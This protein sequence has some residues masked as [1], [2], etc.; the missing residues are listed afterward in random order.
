MDKPRLLLIVLGAALLLGAGGPDAAAVPRHDICADVGDT[1]AFG[2]SSFGSLR[3]WAPEAKSVY[4]A[5]FRFLYVYVL[6]GGMDNPAD[7]RD[8]Y[9]APFLQAARDMDAV[10]VLTFYQLL[11]LGQDAGYSGS[12]PEV[13]AEALQ[14]PDVMRTYFDNFVWL[15]QLCADEGPP[16][17]VHVEPDS[18]GFMQW[19]MGIEGNDDPTSVPVK[20]TGSG[21]P[22]VAGYPDHAAGLGQALVGLRDQ[23]APEVRLGWH[24]SN[25]RVGTHPEVTTSFF[26]QMGDWD[27]LVGEHPHLEPDE[28][29]WWGD[30]DAAAV[31]TNLHWFDEVTTSAGLPM[32]LWQVPIGTMDYHL[33]S[34]PGDLSMLTRFAE[35][36]IVAVLFEHQAFAGETDPDLIR[37]SGALGTPPPSGSPAGG[38]AADMRQR[39]ADYS[40]AP[41]SWPADTL[42][43]SGIDTVDAG[44]PPQADGGTIQGDGGTPPPDDSGDSGCGCRTTDGPA[45]LPLLLLVWL[46]FVGWRRSRSQGGIT[47]CTAL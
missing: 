43:A 12:E 24:A 21:H 46:L 31:D 7:F 35:V 23:Y 42:C 26:A 18:W 1:F 47:R 2:V 15:L 33:L 17:I 9:I 39:V 4:G 22:D 16:I 3:D 45:P 25:F 14:D 36:G 34:A 29:T 11:N 27:V 20:V 44:L 30:W 8:W 32:I 19:A 40:A 41:L 6:A 38:T 10:P 28:S 5:D 37:A 13:V